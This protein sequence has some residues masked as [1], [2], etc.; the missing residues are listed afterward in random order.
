MAKKVT[1]QN[2]G[3]YIALT[4]MLIVAAIVLSVT[5]AVTYLSVDEGQ[6][7]LGNLKAEKS[8]GIIDGCVSEALY[9]LNKTNNV[10]SSITL[11]EG[12]C[13]ITEASSSGTQWQFLVTGQ[14]A[15]YQ[16]KIR[17]TA[18]RVD[19]VEVARWSQE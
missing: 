3:G 11:P 17:V 16:Q 12:T 6:M 10:P 9:K 1:K 14:V 18:N 13:T 5:T 7:S 2:S 19:N 15:S 8:L 4:T